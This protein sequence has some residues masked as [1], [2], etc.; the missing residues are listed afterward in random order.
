MPY[1]TV[2]DLPPAVQKLPENKKKQWM[3]VWTSA[4]NKCGGGKE[5][6]SSAFAQAWGVVKSE[7]ENELYVI[8]EKTEGDELLEEIEK[9]SAEINNLPDSAFAYIE[10]GG[11]KDESGKTIPRSKRHFPVHDA[12]HARNALARLNQ[13]PFGKYAKA[14]VLTAAHKFGIKLDTEKHSKSILANFL[15]KMSDLVST[16]QLDTAVSAGSG[17]I[18]ENSDP[19]P[20]D[21]HVDGIMPEKEKICKKCGKSVEKCSCDVKK[22]DFERIFDIKKADFSRG[23]VYGIVYSPN[24]KDTHGDFTSCEEIERAAHIFLPSALR[25]GSSGWTDIQHKHPV[26]DVEVVESYIAPTDFTINKENVTKGTWVIVAKVNNADLKT[27]I[28]K[29][30][31]T[32]FSLEGTARKLDISI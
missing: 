23:L 5:C 11:E 14:K 15:Q 1:S 29:G 20:S 13:S 25:N 19:Q 4:Y 27:A 32:G 16:I 9:S 6:E 26:D 18:I 28:D 12:N 21:L 7:Y 24:D 2:S 10:P 31:I 30:E 17:E 8:L 3:H 22:E